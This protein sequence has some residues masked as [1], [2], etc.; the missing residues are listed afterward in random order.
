MITFRAVRLT[1]LLAIVL[2]SEPISASQPT[3]A[4][5]AQDLAAVEKARNEAILRRDTAALERIYAEDFSGVAANGQVVNRAQLMEVLKNTDP[6]LMFISDDMNVRVL[7]PGAAVVTGRLTGSGA[8][9]GRDIVIVQR[10]LHVYH[11]RERRWWLVTGQS[12]PVAAPA[13]APLAQAPGA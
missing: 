6:R 1:L 12:T 11:R 2:T 7:A 4:A 13:A 10:F 5:V 9:D 8:I 3:D